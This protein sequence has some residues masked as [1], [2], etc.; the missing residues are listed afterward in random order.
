MY[1]IR[2]YYDI[3]VRIRLDRYNIRCHKRFK[4][5]IRGFHHQLAKGADPHKLAI[6]IYHIDV[7]RHLNIKIFVL[8]CLDNLLCLKVFCQGHVIL[9]HEAAGGILVIAHDLLDI[10]RFFLFHFGQNLVGQFLVQIPEQLGSIIRGHVIKNSHQL[11][12][13]Y[14]FDKPHKGIFRQVSYNFV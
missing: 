9:D 5:L 7:K 2:S 3:S 14:D 6:A 11:V 8:Q 10:V 13:I 12:K 4:R 1:A